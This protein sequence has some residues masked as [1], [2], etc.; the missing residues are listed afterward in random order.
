MVLY[1]YFEKNT[2]CSIVI[3]RHKKYNMNREFSFYEF[4]G[5][6]SPGTIII[7][8]F[9]QLF[10]GVLK[11]IDLEGL[12]IGEFGVFVIIAYTIGHLLQFLGNVIEKIWWC[13]FGGMP[14]NWVIRKDKWDYL[15]EEQLKV[16]LNKISSILKLE[17]K[18]SLTDYKPK[19]WFAITRQIYAAV[20]QNDAAERV[21]IFNVNYGFFR[22]IVSAIAACLVMIVIKSCFTD[23]EVLIVVVAFFLMAIVRMHRFAKHYARELY[24][25]FLQIKE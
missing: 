9:M 25:Q 21:D 6:I 22:G 16:L 13:F 2:A 24:V 20:K 14:T 8:V 1:L 10:P 17:T 5:I 7:I 15:S 3:V 23:W 12:S 18:T 11:V 19:E 4:V